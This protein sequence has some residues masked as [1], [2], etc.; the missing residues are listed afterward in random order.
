MA[1]DREDGAIVFVAGPDLPHAAAEAS[2][3]A[4][5]Y[6]SSRLLMSA[7]ARVDRVSALLDG[8]ALAHLAAHG[9]FRADNPLFSSLLLADGPLTVYDLERLTSTPRLMIL[10]ACDSGLSAVR[11]GDE[12]M[13][14]AAAFLTLGTRSIVASL[15]AA[16]DN[17]TRLLMLALH[18]RL[19]AGAPPRVA[20]A[21]AQ[22]RIAVTGDAG[23]AAAAGFVCLGVG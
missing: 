6:E 1:N 11:P 8:A 9:R 18:A 13:G 14:L 21:D 4:A 12:L 15:I 16:P 10:S 23:L 20:L 3:L 17:E 7:S 19:R 5:S 22:E 2:A